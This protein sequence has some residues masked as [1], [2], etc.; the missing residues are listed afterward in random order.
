MTITLTLSDT[1]VKALQD[2]VETFF[3]SYHRDIVQ[4][5]R[6]LELP[7]ESQDRVRRT[8]LIYRQLADKVQLATH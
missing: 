4:N 8:S 2:S 5:P 7:V 6:L 3:N 1:E